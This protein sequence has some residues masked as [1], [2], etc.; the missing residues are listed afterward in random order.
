MNKF[1]RYLVIGILIAFGGYLF[2]VKTKAQ[3]EMAATPSVNRLHAHVAEVR[4]RLS[5]NH[6]EQD[7]QAYDHIS[8]V[9]QQ[10]FES[11]KMPEGDAHIVLEALFLAGD[12]PLYHQILSET[13][14]LLQTSSPIDRD[15]VVSSI[16][17]QSPVTLEEIKFAFGFDVMSKVQEIVENRAQQIPN[18]L[19]TSKESSVH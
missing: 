16:L 2:I 13:E 7:M 14:K 3:K 9:L 17:S 19:E 8:S 6:D 4:E 5:K 18:E 15:I 1:S 12:A 11:N 10:S